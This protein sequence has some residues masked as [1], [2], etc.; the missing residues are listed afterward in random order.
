M[1]GRVKYD[2]RGV[3]SGQRAVLPAGV[4]VGKITGADVTKPEGKDER[5]E[6]VVTVSDNGTDYKLYEY[7]N[8]ESEAARWK[9]REL[10]EAVQI[11]DGKKGESGVLDPNK[12]LMGKKIG[13]KT[14]I[15]PADDAR[16]FDEQARIRRMFAADEV[17]DDT[18]EDLDDDTEAEADADETPYDD[19]SL[20]ELRKEAR[21]RGIKT[22]RMSADEITE[23]LVEDDDAQEVEPE[24]EAE[25]EPEDE[26]DGM[27]L[28]KLRKLAKDR[29]ISTVRKDKAK[30]I[31]ALREQDQE[32]AEEEPEE[33][34]EEPEAE[35][36]EDDY[37]EWDLDDL[38]QELKDR[39]LATKGPKGALIKRLRRDDS[40]G[41]EPF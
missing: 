14:F 31:A 35:E 3:E 13:V 16:G 20:A 7:V 37:D 28:G 36:P 23:A 10:L 4:W 41:D 17:S 32:E 27:A 6:L 21:G 22:A 9:L 26:Y 12:M 24:A 39:S 8:V 30:L 29:G 2:V 25:E 38:R 1:P 33:A 40:E 19:M 11:V 15:R 18:D 5:I 34:E